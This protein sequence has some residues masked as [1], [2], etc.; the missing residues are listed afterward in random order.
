MGVSN[1]EVIKL[2]AKRV[3]ESDGAEPPV[4]LKF[5]E[6]MDRTK[7]LSCQRQY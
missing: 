4:T 7:D 2:S 1:V 3:F 6:S 5:V